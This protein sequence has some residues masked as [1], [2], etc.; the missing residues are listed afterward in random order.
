MEYDNINTSNVEEVIGQTVKEK[1][2]NI[3]KI[4]N[5]QYL[6]ENAGR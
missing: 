6:E 2:E 3:L 1:I 5:D 4:E